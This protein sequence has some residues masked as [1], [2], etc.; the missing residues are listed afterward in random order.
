MYTTIP[1]DFEVY[2]KLTSELRDEADSYN[3]VLRRILDLPPSERTREPVKSNGIPWVSKGVTLP[4]GTELRA[5]H[6]GKLYEGRVDNGSF[7]VNGHRFKS[8]SA[9]A[10]SI[11]GTSVNGWI[12]WQCRIPGSNTWQTLESFRKKGL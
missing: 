7:A 2:K 4:H 11:T 5:T 1:I 10:H 6:K 3:N 12:F 8:P 9:A